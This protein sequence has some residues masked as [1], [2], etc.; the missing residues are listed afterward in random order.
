MGSS[1][2]LGGDWHFRLL[3]LAKSSRVSSVDASSCH[4]CPDLHWI[5]DVARTSDEEI[6]EF[7]S[8]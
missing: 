3:S 6:S 7:I 2:W 1:N 5:M 8:A 4:S